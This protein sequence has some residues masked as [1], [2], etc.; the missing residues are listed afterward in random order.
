M[1]IYVH[2]RLK[3]YSNYAYPYSWDVRLG[4]KSREAALEEINEAVDEAEVRRI[5]K[6][7]G[8][9]ESELTDAQGGR[10]CAWFCAEE[11]IPAAELRAFLRHHLPDYMIPTR[12]LQLQ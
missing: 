3:G 9:S 2:R 4:H 7:I 8:F 6:E 10:L 11:E 1:G 12:F 5:L